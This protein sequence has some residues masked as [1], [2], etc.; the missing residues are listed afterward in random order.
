MSQ[1][2]KLSDLFYCVPPVQTVV[3]SYYLHNDVVD[4]EVWDIWL[5]EYS[6]KF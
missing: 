5:R 4:F 1:N 6:S 3:V 2:T